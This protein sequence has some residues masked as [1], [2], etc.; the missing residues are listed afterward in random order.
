MKVFEYEIDML[1]ITY[2]HNTATSNVSVMRKRFEHLLSCRWSGPVFT[3]R[4]HEMIFSSLGLKWATND[5]NLNDK[6]WLQFCFKSN[7]IYEKKERLWRDVEFV[8]LCKLSLQLQFE[9]MVIMPCKWSL[10][11]WLQ[12]QLFSSCL[13]WAC[14]PQRKSH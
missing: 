3:V 14:E 2:M 12:A 6:E 1:I 4:A 13:W 8:N 10:R 7:V 11:T 5:V 9:V